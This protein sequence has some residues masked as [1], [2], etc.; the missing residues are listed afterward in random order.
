MDLPFG[1][2][3]PWSLAGNTVG[4]RVETAAEGSSVGSV[5]GQTSA[6]SNIQ[7]PAQIMPLFD[8][9]LFYYEIVSVS[10]CDMTTSHS[11]T[12]Y[13]ISGEMFKWKLWMIAPILLPYQPH[14]S[15][16]YF[17]QTLYYREG[18]IAL[19]HNVKGSHHADIVPVWRRTCSTQEKRKDYYRW[20]KL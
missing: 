8:Y 20:K 18:K 11:S 3:W 1:P 14:S 6:F 4:W 15:R 13:D 16:H 2:P 7:G 12:P 9:K 19:N 17:C 5:Q 10:F